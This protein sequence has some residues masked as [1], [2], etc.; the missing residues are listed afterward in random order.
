MWD[1]NFL[2]VID[3]L[4]LSII[5][6]IAIDNLE[7]LAFSMDY[8]IAHSYIAIFDITLMKGNIR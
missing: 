7:M 6:S 3:L 5:D 2:S 1:G 4:C 8:Q